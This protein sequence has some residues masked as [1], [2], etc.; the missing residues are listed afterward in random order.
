MGERSRKLPFGVLAERFGCRVSSGD[1]TPS[2]CPGLFARSAA[3]RACIYRHQT[4]LPSRQTAQRRGSGRGHKLVPLGAHHG[5]HGGLL[6]ACVR[7]L[8]RRDPSG[9]DLACRG[10]RHAAAHRREPSLPRRSLGH[11]CNRRLGR[12]YSHRRGGAPRVQSVTGFFLTTDSVAV[13]SRGVLHS[14]LAVL[15]DSLSAPLRFQWLQHFSRS[16]SNG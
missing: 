5:V 11:R 4:I 14:T 8:A 10:D 15:L 9:A 7:P 16:S 13:P 3:F 1:R 2:R 6:H 12:R